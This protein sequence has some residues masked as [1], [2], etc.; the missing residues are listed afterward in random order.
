MAEGLP[1]QRPLGSMAAAMGNI[2][3]FFTGSQPGKQDIFEQV[4]YFTR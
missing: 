3:G 1:A 2:L 4:R